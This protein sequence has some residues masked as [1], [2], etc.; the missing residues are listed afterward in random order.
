MDEVSKTLKDLGL[1]NKESK[2][3]SLLLDEGPSSALKVSKISKINR[4][5]TYVIL[6]NLFKKGLV[7]KEK[8]ENSIT[9]FTCS[10][11]KVL[12]DL[13][14][15]QYNKYN[16]LSKHIDRIVE[17]LNLRYFNKSPK[18][19]I[20]LLEG[21]DG[22]VSA[23]NETLKSSE[24]ILAFASIENMHKGI[25]G[26][27]PSYYKKRAERGI[28]I[29]SIHPDTPEA[30]ERMKYNKEEM[31]DGLL[32]S[33]EKY[34]F[35]PEINILENKIFFMSLVER[36]A[37]IIESHELSDAFKKVFELAWAEAKR[38]DLNKKKK[39]E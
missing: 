35:S 25:P 36:F 38:I 39:K 33:K 7:V 30:R 27:F 10:S 18:P 13:F 6:E 17:G 2:I 16:N 9:R 8:E 11:P 20:R 26:Y 4:S 37:V 31:R 5:T 28:F 22:L 19:R 23:Y 34:S 24:T 12:I 1:N 15:N 14:N 29:R 32:I 21:K 3:Y